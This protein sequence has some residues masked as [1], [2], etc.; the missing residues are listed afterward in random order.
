MKMSPDGGLSREMFYA[1][2]WATNT[3]RVEFSGR[4]QEFIRA[5]RYRRETG[6]RPE[7][8]GGECMD[9]WST[10]GAESGES[11][12]SVDSIAVVEQ[13][14]PNYHDP[15]T[16]GVECSEIDGVENVDPPPKL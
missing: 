5:D 14:G 13:S 2:T 6:L 8:R 15:T 9:E 1:C 7:D 16:G 4:A 3:R 11:G 10:D 12:W